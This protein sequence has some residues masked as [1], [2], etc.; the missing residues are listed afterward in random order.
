MSFPRRARSPLS[1]ADEVFTALQRG[2]APLALDPAEL[3][4]PDLPGLEIPGLGSRW[5]GPISLALLQ[6]VLCRAAT[7]AAVK[8][9]AW[10]ALVARAQAEGGAWTVGAVGVA[11]PKL[12]RL[13]TEL[14]DG[15]REGRPELD[16]E[17]LSGFLQGLTSANPASPALFPRVLREARRAGVAWLR[18]QRA[19][20]ALIH[21]GGHTSAPPPAPWGHPDLVLARAVAAGVLTAAEAALIGATRLEGI[22]PQTIALRHS[23]SDQAVFKRRRRAEQRLVSYL[24]DELA[25]ANPVDPTSTEALLP[26]RPAAVVDPRGT[27]QAGA[28]TVRR[29]S[30]PKTGANRPLYGRGRSTRSA[31]S[32]PPV[33]AARHRAGGWA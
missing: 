28:V 22:S 7:P 32:A 12:V 33:P 2:P 5:T 26:A 27:S 25:H 6:S 24:S 20:D 17:I 16:T 8:N 21:D 1:I 23:L 13:A 3:A 29:S 31:G 18:H 11:L 4:D 9:R 19:A 14:A 30:C 10:S 15:D